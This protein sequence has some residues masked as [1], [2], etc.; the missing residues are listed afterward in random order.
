[1]AS[2]VAA[3]DGHDAANKRFSLK[4]F[5]QRYGSAY[6]FISP[7]FILYA[8]FGLY[9]V[10]YSFALS[11]HNWAGV[12][13]W[14]WIGL[15][16]YKAFVLQDEVFRIG[17]LNTVYYW[18]GLVPGMTFLALVMAVIMNQ[19]GLKLR[20]LF[21]TVYILP[22]ITSAVSIA[23]VFQNL[24]DDQV[25]WL[26]FLLVQVGLSKVPFLRSTEWSKFSVILMVIWKW[27]GYNMII[28]LAGL[29]SIPEELYEVATIDGAGPVSRFTHVTVPLMRPVILFS[30]IMSTIGTFNMFT[31]PY[32]LTDGGPSY[33]SSTLNTLLYNTAFRYGR[34]G[35]AAALSFIIAALIFVASLLQIRL[36]TREV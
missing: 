2:D 12:G 9:P 35:A 26:N 15:A 28:M 27:V 34:F 30:A 32:V 5:L 13:P 11:F 31:E 8:I 3:I 21:R 36:S 29:Q 14:K 24:L 4:L 23:I 1:M 22:Y 20:G 18:V 19:K 33:S 6:L 10:L 16:N 17:F 7:F 25:G